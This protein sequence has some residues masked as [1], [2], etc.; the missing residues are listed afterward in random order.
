MAGIYIV[1][2]QNPELEDF[3]SFEILDA[4]INAELLSFTLPKELGS[5]SMRKIYFEAS[6]QTPNTFVSVFGRAHC[7]QNADSQI[8]C[9]IEYNSIYQELLTELLPK[10]ELELSQTIISDQ[11][12][13]NRTEIARQ[14]SSDPIGIL[15]IGL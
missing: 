11:E 10:T 7:L 14:F 15:I 2:V 6:E 8:E 1:P 12:L 13:A 9:N 5:T 4:H 3:S